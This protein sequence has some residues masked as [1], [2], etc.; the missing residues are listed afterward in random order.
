MIQ[1]ITSSVSLPK[2][3]VKV[4][5][6]DRR[7]NRI[8]DCFEKE[9]PFSQSEGPN[10]I[11]EEYRKIHNHTVIGQHEYA[12]KRVEWGLGSTPTE[13][14]MTDL[15]SPFSPRVFTPITDNIFVNQSGN[16]VKLVSELK[17]VTI[18]GGLVREIALRTL[19]INNSYD[20][21]PSGIMG[22][23]FIF[24]SD[25]PYNPSLVIGIEWFI[26]SN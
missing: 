15:S 22:A 11:V 21:Y 9:L 19:P 16:I 10:T 6:R 4:T 18:P 3:Y 8:I 25:Y 24:E 14:S 1:V 26:I 5:V 17:D 23:R 2:G 20:S 12:I 7:T 13:T